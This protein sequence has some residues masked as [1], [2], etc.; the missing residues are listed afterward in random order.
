MIIFYTAATSQKYNVLL[1]RQ[2][3]L[4]KQRWDWDWNWNWDW[5]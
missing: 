4:T 1:P 5:D 3:H 2:V